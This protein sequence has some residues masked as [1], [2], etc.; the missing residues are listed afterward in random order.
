MGSQKSLHIVECL[1]NSQLPCGI[2]RTTTDLFLLPYIEKGG[3]EVNALY[4]NVVC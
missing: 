2:I 3:G 4:G 1:L